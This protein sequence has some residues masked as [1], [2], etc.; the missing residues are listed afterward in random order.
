MPRSF[1]PTGNYAQNVAYRALCAELRGKRRPRSRR[2]APVIAVPFS[3]PD[4]TL[5][6][7][8]ANVI[9]YSYFWQQKLAKSKRYEKK[10]AA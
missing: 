5:G 1:T 6:K 7:W 8:D 4:N 10:R 9:P 3:P 2:P